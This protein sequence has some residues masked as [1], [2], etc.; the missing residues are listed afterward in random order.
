MMVM[1]LTIN[2]CNAFRTVST[3]LRAFYWLSC[4][5]L[6]RDLD[7]HTRKVKSNDGHYEQ[8]EVLP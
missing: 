1:G 3:I 2:V 8:L 6:F 4:P 5:Q 7:K